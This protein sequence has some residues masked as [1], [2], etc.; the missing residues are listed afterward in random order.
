MI[1]NPAAAGEGIS[2][3]MACHHAIYLDRSFN[4][5]HYLQS[6]DRIHRLGLPPEI[7]TNVEILEA[8][9]TVDGRVASRMNSKIDTMRIILNDPGLAAL[10]YDPSDIEEEFGAGIEPEDVE[11]I[12]DHLETP[13]G[14]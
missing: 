3:H 4:A 14:D 8:N 9:G 1:A 2:L 7:E 11:E 5:A 12:L 10:S 13:E 6:V